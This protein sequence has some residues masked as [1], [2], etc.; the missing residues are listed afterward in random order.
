M[1]VGRICTR[2]VAVARRGEPLAAAA[3]RMLDQH[4][5]S[6]VVVDDHGG[7]AFPVGI[8]TDRDVLRAQLHRDAD[9]NLL[10]V[11][12]ALSSDPLVVRDSDTLAAAIDALQARGVRRAPVIDDSGALVG[13]LALDDALAALAAQLAQVARLVGHQ[14]QAEAR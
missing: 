14:R 11:G 7:G 9:L 1:T 10:N 6:L 4:V 3:Q 2:V 12:D 8:V 5:G 13:L